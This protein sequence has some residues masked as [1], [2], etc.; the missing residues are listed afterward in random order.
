MAGKIFI[1]TLLMFFM[2]ALFAFGGAA[3]AEI[4][5]I[6]G[7]EGSWGDFQLW[8]GSHV[9][10][11][12][13]DVIIS[14]AAVFC[15]SSSSCSAASLLLQTNASLE[16]YNNVNFNVQNITILGSSLSS[17]I[18]IN[19]SHLQIDSRSSISTL[20]NYASISLTVLDNLQ[21][22]AVGFDPVHDQIDLQSVGVTLLG[23]ASADNVTMLFGQLE[24][25]EGAS[26]LCS[27]GGSAPIHTQIDVLIIDGNVVMFDAFLRVGNVS[28]GSNGQFTLSGKNEIHFGCSAGNEAG[29]LNE[30]GTIIIFT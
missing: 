4:S 5:W 16:I 21:A 9:P 17:A 30:Q 27:Q 25:A 15:S 22:I 1:S 20:P 7:S 26:F 28:Y 12:S 23:N 19:I 8:S 10:T 2:L 14:N 24:V 3:S 11:D 6:G 18:S 29:K 13:D